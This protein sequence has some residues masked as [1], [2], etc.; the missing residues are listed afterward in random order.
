MWTRG[1]HGRLLRSGNG[2]PRAFTCLN[3]LRMS[4][5]DLEARA[6]HHAKEAERLLTGRLGLI[7]NIIKAGVHAT[8]AVYYAGQAQRMP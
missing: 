8:L 6:E 4:D 7:T 1:L 5:P 2:S 3:V